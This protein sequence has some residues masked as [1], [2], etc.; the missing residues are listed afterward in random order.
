MQAVMRSPH[1]HKCQQYRHG[2]CY[3]CSV[4]GTSGTIEC[5]SLDVREALFVVIG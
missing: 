4:T 1:L 3:R 2:G 5:Y